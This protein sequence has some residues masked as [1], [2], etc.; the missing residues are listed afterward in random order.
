MDAKGLFKRDM[1]KIIE[2]QKDELRKPASKFGP[3]KR[4]KEKNE[5]IQS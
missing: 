4:K 3:A 1:K 2:K 5:T